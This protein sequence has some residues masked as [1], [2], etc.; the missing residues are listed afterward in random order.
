METFI[1]IWVIWKN[2]LIRSALRDLGQIQSHSVI[3]FREEQV[4]PE[5]CVDILH[6]R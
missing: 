4:M 3:V 5:L 2:K 1:K 6:V